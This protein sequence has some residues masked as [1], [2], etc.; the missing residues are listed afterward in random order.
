MNRIAEATAV[1]RE[2]E[3]R[4]PDNLEFLVPAAAFYHRAKLGTEAERCFL[5]ILAIA[6]ARVATYNDLARLYSDYAQFSKARELCQKGLELEPR[7][8]VLWNTL[9]NA[10]NSIGLIDESIRSYKTVL[11]LAPGLSGCALQPASGHA[12]SK[13]HRPR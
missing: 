8:P 3:G 2:T 4:F 10:Q 9:A 5:R 13:Q 11:E 6:P 7:S 12:L 1:F